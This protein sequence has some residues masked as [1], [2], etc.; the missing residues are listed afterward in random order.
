MRIPVAGLTTQR[1]EAGR[2]AS[3]GWRL[4]PAKIKRP[5]VWP[6]LFP[7]KYR[8]CALSRRRVHQALYRP[9]Y[10]TLDVDVPYLR[11]PDLA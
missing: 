8:F 7:A 4:R 5:G 6:G 2:G 1:Q 9:L 3:Q 10:G 11:I